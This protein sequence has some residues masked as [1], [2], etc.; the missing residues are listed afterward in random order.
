M[1]TGVSVNVWPLITVVIG[2]GVVP[3]G[4]DVGAFPVAGMVTVWP[5]RTVNV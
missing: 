4:P 2:A 3:P 1:A 5:A